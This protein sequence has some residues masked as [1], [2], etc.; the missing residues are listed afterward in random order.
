MALFDIDTFK[1][2][3]I[4]AVEDD[5]SHRS[6]YGIMQEAFKDTAAIES[7]FGTPSEGGAFPL[8]V[9]GA[10]TIANVVWQPGMSV[11]P[12]NHNMWAVIGVYHGREDNIFWQRVRGDKDDRIK[13]VGAEALLPGDVTP[14]GKDIIHS[15]INPIPKFSAAIHVYGGNF[16][17]QERSE[18][19]PETL[20]G[21]TYD[22]EKSLSRFTE[23][24]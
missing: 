6:V 14:L 13:A 22:V 7:A 2:A 23:E 20:I 19:D 17:E 12:H 16:F 8:H 5:P 1:D 3:C 15:V 21:G 11:P 24:S 9:S 18:W 10:L 4:K